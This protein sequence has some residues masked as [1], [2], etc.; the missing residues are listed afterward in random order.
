MDF[1]LSS[2]GREQ[3]KNAVD[4]I[5][6]LIGNKKPLVFSSDLLRAWETAMIICEELKLNLPIPDKRLRERN[7]GD[8]QNLH[9]TTID[10]EIVNGNTPDVPAL[11]SRGEFT[12]RIKNFLTF[13]SHQKKTVG[14]TVIAVTHGGTL[15]FIYH[16]LLKI[17]LDKVP[18]IRNAAVHVFN[19]T[20]GSWSAGRATTGQAPWDLDFDSDAVLIDFLS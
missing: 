5:K 10:W 19:L 4:A 14:E 18:Y 13:V 16:L 3:A 6:K 15:T 11:E 8:L 2:E 9:W 7:M 1:Q 17:D 12:Q 20:E